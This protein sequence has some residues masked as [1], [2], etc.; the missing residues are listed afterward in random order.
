LVQNLHTKRNEGQQSDDQVSALIESALVG[1][2]LPTGPMSSMSSLR[3]QF[4]T[5]VM[6]GQTT[7]P[8]N[9]ADFMKRITGLECT[10][11]TV[12]NQP[13]P[14]SNITAPLAPQQ[15]AVSSASVFQDLTAGFEN[16]DLM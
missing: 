11:N 9:L 6:G 5:Q 8:L 13:I 14:M 12:L 2:K 3:P 10:E 1:Q 15:E 7:Q 16:L 4:T